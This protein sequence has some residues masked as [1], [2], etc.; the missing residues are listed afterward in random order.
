MGGSLINAGSGSEWAWAW[1]RLR[2]AEHMGQNLTPAAPSSRTCGKCGTS[3]SEGAGSFRMRRPD[4]R[5]GCLPGAAP[6]TRGDEV[7]PECGKTCRPIPLLRKGGPTRS[8]I[9]PECGRAWCEKQPEKVNEGDVRT[10]YS[11]KG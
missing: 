3:V 6:P 1:R 7:C 9:L 2:V 10:G 8:E 11:R 5:R 4:A